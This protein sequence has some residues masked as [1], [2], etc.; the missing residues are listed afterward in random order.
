MNYE[1]NN[2]SAGLYLPVQPLNS[3]DN[4][5]PYDPTLQSAQMLIAQKPKNKLTNPF[6][7]VALVIIILLP[8]NIILLLKEALSPQQS[9]QP[10]QTLTSLDDFHQDARNLS[11]QV[12][13]DQL[14][15]YDGPY[16]SYWR[17]SNQEPM[18]LG[19]CLVIERIYHAQTKAGRKGNTCFLGKTTQNDLRDLA[20]VVR[21]LIIK[22]N[23]AFLTFRWSGQ[24]PSYTYYAFHIV[25]SGPGPDGI[26]FLSKVG[27]PKP[28]LT[29]RMTLS[30][31]FW[32]PG[33][34]ITIGFLATGDDISLYINNRIIKKL[35]DPNSYHG[36]TIGLSACA[37]PNISS[38]TN[39][40]SNISDVMYS[41]LELWIPQSS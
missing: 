7:V 37:V 15:D 39:D 38:D 21:V 23:E 1:N 2:P 11:W 6:F 41:N 22:G 27:D 26:C 33:K 3:A 12:R 9:R 35:R 24:S 13:Y 5:H 36:G 14:T 34:P 16:G 18:D 28:D 29:G 4:P 30:K 25:R 10:V 31:V 32:D 20:V 19:Y 17:N 40:R 8:G